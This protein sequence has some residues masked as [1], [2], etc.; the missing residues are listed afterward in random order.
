MKKLL[1]SVSVLFSIGAFAQ[2]PIMSFYNSTG[3]LGEVE[4]NQYV[5]VTSASGPD[6]AAAGAN[7]AWNFNDLAEI[8]QTSTTTV[9]ATANDIAGFPGSTWVVKTT[10]QGG[11]P[12]NYYIAQGE[13]T[14]LTGLE[15]S[16]LT[17]KYND[18]ALV[19]YFPMEYQAT[20]SSNVSGTFEG[21]GVE[22]TFT[23]TTS[24]VVDAYG[25]LTVNE[26]FE[27]P[28]NVTRLKT[29]QSLTLNYMGFPVGTIDQTT[30]SYYGSDLIT[31]PV[32]R[33]I[34][35]HIVVTGLGIDQTQNT[36]ESYFQT[37]N[38]NRE[39]ALTNAAI[40]PNPVQDVLH[41]AGNV[42]IEKITIIDALGRTVV[43][44]TG[45]DVPVGHLPAGIYHVAVA[46]GTAGTTLKMIRQ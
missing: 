30:Y 8:T 20:A 13:G 18:F 22:G 10:T 25:V 33:S 37:T 3:P 45:N 36:L 43:Q 26:G 6:Q 2:G 34:S 21:Q 19:G 23:G 39:F 24:S 5:L 27:G 1:L 9:P 35:T 31:G 42:A 40:A 16:Q 7:V 41:I 28:K 4:T 15:T 29:I 14:Y 17:I 12:S 46:S 44:A 11:N 32:F 38:S